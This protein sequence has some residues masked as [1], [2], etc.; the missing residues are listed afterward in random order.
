[1]EDDDGQIVEAI[2]LRITQ[3]TTFFESTV[4]WELPKFHFDTAIM[5]G[6][7][8]EPFVHAIRVAG[9]RKSIGDY[10]FGVIGYAADTVLDHE[11]KH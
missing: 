9:A 2:F 4:L 1:M 6:Y 3:S 8:V 10:L 11:A 7:Y 5:R